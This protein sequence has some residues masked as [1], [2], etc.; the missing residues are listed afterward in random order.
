MSKPTGA[1]PPPPGG[2][3]WMSDMNRGGVSTR[4][5]LSSLLSSPSRSWPDSGLRGAGA[6]H[7]DTHGGL[8]GLV[9]SLDGAQLLSSLT[10]TLS[11]AAVRALAAQ[12]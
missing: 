10:H 2:D 5:A 6:S 11:E 12:A 7:A 9:R 1:S 8:V 3:E 4:S